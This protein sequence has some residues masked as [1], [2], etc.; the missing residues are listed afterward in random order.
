LILRLPQ[1]A[2]AEIVTTAGSITVKGLSQSLS[3]N[4]ESGPIRAELTAPLDVDIIARS[5]TGSVRESLGSETATDP[6][7]FQSRFGSGKSVLRANSQRGDITLSPFGAKARND[8]APELQGPGRTRAAG[9]PANQQANEEFGEGDTIRV[10]AQ[11]VTM[12]LS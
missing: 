1:Q 3:L 5:T 9:T 8:R 4:T 12:N 10:D 11:L 7:L 6:H 2:R